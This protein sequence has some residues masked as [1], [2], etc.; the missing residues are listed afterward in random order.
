MKLL[1]V[2]KFLKN[3]PKKAHAVILVSA[4]KEQ[5]IITVN[6]LIK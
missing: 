1:F 3:L 6:E 2:A 4:V 5:T